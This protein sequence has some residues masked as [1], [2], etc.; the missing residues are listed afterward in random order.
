MIFDIKE[1]GEVVLF[2]KDSSK[3]EEH[4]FVYKLINLD[5]ILSDN[6]SNDIYIAIP[7]GQKVSVRDLP[8]GSYYM[9]KMNK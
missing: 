3:P 8:K 1:K 2:A 7:N 6:Y 9:E 5:C 4:I